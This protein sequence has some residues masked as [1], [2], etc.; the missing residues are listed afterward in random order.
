MNV[1]G[2]CKKGFLFVISAPAGTG[3]TTLVDKLC[4]EF[5]CVVRSISCT[6][7]A[8]RKGEQEGKDYF[9]L[10]SEEFEQRIK[11]HEFL[12]HAT[13]F[14]HSYGTSRPFIEEQQKEGKHVILVIDTQGALQIMAKSLPAIFIFIRPPSLAELRKRLQGRKTETEAVVEERLS[15]A[16]KEMA[17]APRY[18]YQIV[19]DHLST[20]Y[21]VLRAIFIAEEHK[22]RI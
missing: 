15:W 7:R 20:A 6:T 2:N 5:P 14:G 8:K 11:N 16:E 13:V 19:N 12:E 1:L 10:K 3:K 21:D 9:F 22:N 4:E 17:L 18:H